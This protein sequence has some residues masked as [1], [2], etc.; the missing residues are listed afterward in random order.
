MKPMPKAVEYFTN[1]IVRRVSKSFAN[2]EISK[3]EFDEILNSVEE[4]RTITNKK[5]G[6]DNAGDQNN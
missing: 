1:E 5:E 4:I 2:S 6:K 3:Q